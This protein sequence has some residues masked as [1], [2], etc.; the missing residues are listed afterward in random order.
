MQGNGAKRGQRPGTQERLSHPD[1]YVEMLVNRARTR[2]YRP[3]ISKRSK[4]C[5]TAAAPLHAGEWTSG[6]EGALW[7]LGHIGRTRLS[8]EDMP[9]CSRKVVAGDPAATIGEDAGR[10]QNHPCGPN[11]AGERS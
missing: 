5:P 1:R 3:N 4:T 8:I 11:C 9:G 2:S 6:V 10:N 7:S